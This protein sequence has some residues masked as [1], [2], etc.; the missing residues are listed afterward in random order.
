MLASYQE[1]WLKILERGIARSPATAEEFDI[2]ISFLELCSEESL[3]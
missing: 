2:P 3:G 1:D